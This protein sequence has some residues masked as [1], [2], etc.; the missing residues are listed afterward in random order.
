MA[1]LFCT[2]SSQAQLRWHLSQHNNTLPKS[3]RVYETTD[4][5]DGK[6]FRAFYL[7]ADLKDSNLDFVT[8]VGN[9]KRY[10]PSQYAEQEGPKTLAVINTTFF[11]FADNS[12][13]NIVMHDGK[14]LA[15]NPK[16]Y[17]QKR[18]K[19]DSVLVYPT[20]GAFGISKRGK[21]DVAWVYNVGKEQ[22]PYA[23]DLP[24]TE[25]REPGKYSPAGA[26]AWKMDEAIGGGPVL[27][28]DGKPFITAKEEDRAGGLE[29]MHPRTAIGYT[30]KG[31]LII[32]VVEGRN[33][34]VAEG[35][36]FPQMAKIFRDL[37]CE[38]ALNLDGG[39]SSCLWVN[40]TNTIKVSDGMQRPVPAVFIIRKK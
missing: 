12:N 19:T 2:A 3:V 13:L 21:P 34:G 5:L 17:Y 33:K 32:L 27:L 23:Y 9:G 8:R 6:P 11:S 15:P 24:N 10:T 18:S 4:S 16:G 1:A 26:H 7:T 39:G 30:K 25:A 22:Q 29:A 28:K 40:G 14:V 35:A 37:G 31:K 20:R 38:E 36:N